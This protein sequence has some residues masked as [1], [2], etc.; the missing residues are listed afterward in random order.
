MKTTIVTVIAIASLVSAGSVWASGSRVIAGDQNVHV[1]FAGDA[2]EFAFDVTRAGVVVG[3]LSCDEAPAPVPQVADADMAVQRGADGAVT[4]TV[5]VAGARTNPA[6][7]TMKFA[8]TTAQTCSMNLVHSGVVTN[9]RAAG[10]NAAAAL[11]EAR[12]ADR[13]FVVVIAQPES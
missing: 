4:F 10:N 9:F 6:A 5:K 3:T 13:P 11:G 1:D 2:A 7:M 8:A 12:W